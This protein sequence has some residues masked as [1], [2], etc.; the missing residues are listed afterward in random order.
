MKSKQNI[1]IDGN[2]NAEKIK[3]ERRRSHVPLACANIRNANTLHQTAEYILRY[4]K[5]NI[6]NIML[7]ILLGYCICDI[8]LFIAVLPFYVVQCVVMLH[9]QYSMWS[10]VK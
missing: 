8:L 5:K 7:P 4:F 1:W 2:G 3:H 6:T 9:E 10:Y